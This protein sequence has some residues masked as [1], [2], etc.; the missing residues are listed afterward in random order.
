[1]RPPFLYA[2]FIPSLVACKPDVPDPIW[3][4][5]HLYYGTTTS[6]P[7]CRGSFFR[8]E[9]HVVGLAEN[10]AIVLPE[11]IYYTRVAD[12][13]IPDY[14]EGQY[15]RGCAHV[16]SPYVFSLKSFHYHELAHAVAYLAGMDGAIPFSEGFAEVFN[17]GGQPDTERLPI[18]DVLQNFEFDD[19]NYYTMGLFSRFLIE[20]H[21]LE[22]FVD[23]LRSSDRDS[24]FAQFAPIF[25]DVFGEPIEAA[26][27]DFESYPSCREMSNR[28]AVVDCSLPL[29]PWQGQTVT[30][31][32]NLACD[33]DDVLGPTT[34]NLMLTTRGFQI[35]QPGSYSLVPSAPEGLSGF[36]VIKCGSC[37]DSFDITLA[38][39]SMEVHELTPGRYYVLFGRDVNEPAE[40][41]LAVSQL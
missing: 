39:A 35:E 16:A 7:V 6:E 29:E 26:M 4:G 5:T 38:P 17:D 34:D 18:D 13:E 36:R 14:C 22:A 28:L 12:A 33:Q 15:L 11:I 24:S 9:Q 31:S 41:S 8:Q 2:L 1:M 20:R 37:W 3:K 40:L 23:F 32:A 10:L 21:G 27:A 30:L 19:P 25:E